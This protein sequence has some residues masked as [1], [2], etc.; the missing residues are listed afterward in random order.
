M[1]DRKKGDDPSM[2]IATNMLRSMN[3]V[4][5]VKRMK[6]IGPSTCLQGLILKV[7]GVGFGVSD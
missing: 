3:I 4:R 5:H 7:E 2:I 1:K 6:Y